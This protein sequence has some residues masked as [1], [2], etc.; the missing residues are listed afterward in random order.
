MPKNLREEFKKPTIFPAVLANWQKLI[1]IFFS[2]LICIKIGL[3]QLKVVENNIN[4]T[5]VICFVI[6]NAQNSTVTSHFSCY[7]HHKEQ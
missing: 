1:T 6:S 7:H 5:S 3:Q 2:E 4:F